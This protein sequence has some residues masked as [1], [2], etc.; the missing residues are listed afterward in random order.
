M[1]VLVG[2]QTH[3]H[4]TRVQGTEREEGLTAGRDGRMRV[5]VVDVLLCNVLCKT[6][7]KS[8]V[9]RQRDRENRERTIRAGEIGTDGRP[10]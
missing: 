5:E 3:T 4:S 10:F 7:L 9:Q 8:E 1:L 2:E 6:T